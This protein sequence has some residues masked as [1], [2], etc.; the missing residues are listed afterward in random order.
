MNMMCMIKK[1]LLYG[2][3][4]A[5]VSLPV[6]GQTG[7]AVSADQRAGA[8]QQESK[9]SEAGRNVKEAA[10]SVADATKETTGAAWDTV[11]SGSSSMWEKTKEGSKEAW[12]ATKEG[13]KEAWQATKEGSK[14]AWEKGKALIHEATAPDPP[15]APPSPDAP[16]APS[17]PPATAPTAP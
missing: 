1:M 11:K 9:W 15:S 13:S 2:C 3:A 17:A 12:Q 8:P 5:M 16:P 10:G 14:D 4:M 7:E 6:A